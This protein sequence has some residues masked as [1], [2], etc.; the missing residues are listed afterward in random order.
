MLGPEQGAPTYDAPAG[1]GVGQAIRDPSDGGTARSSLAYAGA[2]AA[3]ALLAGGLLLAPR[4][5][6]RRRPPPNAAVH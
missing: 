1:P 2:G 3:A 4:A 5:G 6:R